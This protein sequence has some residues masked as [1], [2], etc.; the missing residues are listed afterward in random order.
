MT[1]LY[2]V[3]ALVAIQRIA[4]LIYAERN[5]RRLRERGGIEVAAWQHPLFV[6]LHAAWLLSLLAFI[7]HAATAN[8]WLLG[9]FLTLQLA[10]LWVV[11]SLGPYWTTRIITLPTAPLVRRGSYRFVKHPN[12]TIVVLE[13]ALLP[14][15]FG[16][17]GIALVFSAINAILLFFRIRAED[18][19]LAPRGIYQT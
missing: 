5:T 9:A 7:P 12:Y 2:I 18:Y 14:L 1:V 13:I 17:W 16:A 11:A 15:A 4:E 6:A 8:W 10:R 3:I 19:A